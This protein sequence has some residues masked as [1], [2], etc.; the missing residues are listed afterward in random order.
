MRRMA[1]APAPT[2][3]SATVEDVGTTALTAGAV[4]LSLFAIPVMRKGTGNQIGATTAGT[5]VKR[6]RIEPHLRGKYRWAS[7]CC[8]FACFS[9]NQAHIEP[10]VPRLR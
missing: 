7:I 1:R 5:P 10:D 3:T 8:I 4:A 2:T 9:N 6:T